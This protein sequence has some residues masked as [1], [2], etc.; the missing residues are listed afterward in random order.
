MAATDSRARRDYDGPALLESE[1]ADDP[2]VQFGRWFSD[3]LKAGF[4]EPQAMVLATADA[5]GTPSARMVLLKEWDRS[6]FVFY[7]NFDSRKGRELANNPRAAL[8]FYWDRLHRQVRIEGRVER[9]PDAM[10]D[11][12][13][14]VRPYG[15]QIGAWASRQSAPVPDRAWLEARV[16][17]LRQRY[18][19][20]VPRPAWW[21]GFRVVPH[22]FEF[23]QGRPDR[24]H[25]RLAYERTDG[26][27]R[28]FRLSP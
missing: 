12:Y 10:A 25:D 9:V 22:W 16:E 1:A 6:G 18:P 14:A 11:A 4:I 21:G 3:M 26:G 17:E 2:F 28:R 5:A 24:L 23:W 20:E 7:T 13:F 8:L 15:S 19:R 27:W